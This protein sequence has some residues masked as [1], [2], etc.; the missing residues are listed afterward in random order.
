VLTED[1]M[2]ALDKLRKEKV[3]YMEWQNATASLDR[4]RRFCIAYRYV[5]SKGL[6]KD[7]EGDISGMQEQVS[8]IEAQLAALELSVREKDDEIQGLQ[9]EKEL[10]SGGE[11]KELMQL[12]DDVSKR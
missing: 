1:I 4:L 2:P 9:T 6:Q 3:Q 8:D 7:G 5:E 12:V 10:Q 11:L